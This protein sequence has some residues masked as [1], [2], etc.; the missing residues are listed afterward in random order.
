MCPHRWITNTFSAGVMD[1]PRDRL[2]NLVMPQ[3]HVCAAPSFQREVLKAARPRPSGPTLSGH[4][5]WEAPSCPGKHAHPLATSLLGNQEMPP[6]HFT[7]VGI[8]PA[9]TRSTAQVPPNSAPA[10]HPWSVVRAEPEAAATCSVVSV[11]GQQQ[12]GLRPPELD[13]L[14]HANQSLQ[15]HAV[16]GITAITP[17]NAAPAGILLAGR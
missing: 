5:R 15:C 11:V 14:R 17:R 3:N 16:P 7:L 2:R 1:H 9:R 10:A 6:H 8:A 4:G 13:L 12:R